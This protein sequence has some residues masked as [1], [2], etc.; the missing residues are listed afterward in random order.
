MPSTKSKSRDGE[1][2]ALVQ[3]VSAQENIDSTSRMGQAFSTLVALLGQAE[4]EWLRERT[5]HGSAPGRAIP[6]STE[7]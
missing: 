2:V 5:R 7:P 1:R 4:A 6:A 3:L